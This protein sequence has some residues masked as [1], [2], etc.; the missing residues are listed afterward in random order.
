MRTLA[1]RQPSKPYRGYEVSYHP[2]LREWSVDLGPRNRRAHF[3]SWGQASRAIEAFLLEA[4]DEQGRGQPDWSPAEVRAT[5]ADYLA[6]LF[7][8]LTGAPYSKRAHRRALRPFLRGR[9]EGAIELKH[10]NISGVLIE[11]GLPYIRGYKPRGHYQQALVEE[12]GRQVGDGSE[13]RDAM[14]RPALVPIGHIRFVAVPEARYATRARRAGAT[15]RTVD[16]GILEAENRA[17]GRRGEDLVYRLESDRLRRAGRPDL[18]ERVEWVA[19][20]IGDGLGYDIRSYDADG[21]EL[22][23][24]VKTTRGGALTPFYISAAELGVARADSAFRLYRLFDLEREPQIYVLTALDDRLDLDAVTYRASLRS[25][26][27]SLTREQKEG[28]RRVTWGPP[29]DEGTRAVVVRDVTPR[30]P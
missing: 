24:E 1:D 18:A 13:I 9:S 16:Y 26:R 21:G 23:I 15:T 4:P 14:I 19:R 2:R 22:H 28:R 7:A 11:L 25:P 17:L 29:A 3:K 6:M 10:A 8:E 30:R 20:D 5:V 27:P 12:I